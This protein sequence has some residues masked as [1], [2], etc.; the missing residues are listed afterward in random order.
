MPAVADVA[1]MSA[2]RHARDGLEQP[3]Q[4]VRTSAGN[5]HQTGQ[6]RQMFSEINMA[7]RTGPK[8]G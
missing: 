4:V 2:W 5:V 7:A 1:R 6:R 8:A 3:M